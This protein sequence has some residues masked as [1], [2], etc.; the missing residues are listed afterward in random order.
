MTAARA[1]LPFRDA[2]LRGATLMYHVHMPIRVIARIR[3]VRGREST[4]EVALRA[5]LEPTRREP[6]CRRYELYRSVEDPRDFI[7]D[8]EWSDEV[9]H[10]THMKAPHVAQVLAEAGPFLAAPPDIRRYAL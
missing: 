5:L 10:E 8:E 7:F 6:G 3:A 1:V 9:A 4:V 2:M